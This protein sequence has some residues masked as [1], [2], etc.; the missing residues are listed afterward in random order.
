[1]GED[2]LF[3]TPDFWADPLENGAT[4][5]TNARKRGNARGSNDFKE[6]PPN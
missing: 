6:G 2:A 3:T 4:V 5:K 1:L